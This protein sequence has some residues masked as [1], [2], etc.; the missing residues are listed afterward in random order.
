[1]SSW[2]QGIGRVIK[3]HV[4]RL[5][6]CCV[7]LDALGNIK[8]LSNFTNCSGFCPELTE[9]FHCFG[10]Q[11]GDLDLGVRHAV[12]GRLEGPSSQRGG[13]CKAHVLLE[14]P[15]L[16]TRQAAQRV[17]AHV[18]EHKVLHATPSQTVPT[19]N[20]I[21]VLSELNHRIS[22]LDNGVQSS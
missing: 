12:G 21:F 1:M 13:S 11:S 6:T 16:P 9:D 2:R 15:R 7:V 18:E 5:G 19:E 17:T 22:Q 3:D 10:Q 8:R 20:F 4:L 14:E